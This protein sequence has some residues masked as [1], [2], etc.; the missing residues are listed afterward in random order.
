MRSSP[1]NVAPPQSEPA[2]CGTHVNGLLMNPVAT[3]TGR[4]SRKYTP[5]RAHKVKCTGRG[6]GG[7]KAMN[8]PSANERVTLARLKVQQR[9]PSMT[10]VKCLRHQW[11][12]SVRRSGVMDLSQ[13][14]IVLFITPPEAPLCRFRDACTRLVE[15]LGNQWLVAGAKSAV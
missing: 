8:N 2:T 13:R 6:V 9:G 12:S 14:F 1:S 11:F 5:S 7:M 4:L 3:S 15:H 10:A